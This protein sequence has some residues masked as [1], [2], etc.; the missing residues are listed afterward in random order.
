MRRFRNR[1]PSHR[2]RRQPLAVCLAAILGA[3]A[4]MAGHGVSG[5]STLVVTNCDDAGAGSLRDAI[6][7]AVSGDTIDLRQLGCSLIT[8]SGGALAIGPPIAALNLLGPG[9]ASLTIDGADTDRI[10]EHDVGIDGSLSISGITLTH[11]RSSGDGGCVSVGGSVSLTDVVVASCIV[12][13]AP[14]AVDAHAS[15][16]SGPNGSVALHGGGV[17]AKSSA[18]LIDSTVS[19]NEVHAN[20][21]RAY[22]GGVY[23]ASYLSVTHSTVSGNLA[24]SATVEAYGGG[25]ASGNAAGGAQG[26]LVVT[27]S[28]LSSNTVSSACEVCLVKG[29]A[30]WSYG[31]ATVSGSLIGANGVTSA[32]HYA[33]GG[34]MYFRARY[35]GAPV[36]ATLSDTT[37]TGNTADSSAGGIGAGGSLDLIRCTLSDNVAGTDGGAVALFSGDMHL[38]DSTLSGNQ[39]SGRGGGAFLFGYGD[40][41]ASN[42]TISANSADRGGAFANTYGSLHLANS[43]IAFNTT[44]GNGGG[45]YFRY[46]SYT[47]D[48]QSTIVAG[49]QAVAGAQDIWAPG[50]SVSGANNLVM[51]APDVELPADT[52][53]DDPLLQPLADNG[54]PTRTHAFRVGS[55]AI[56]A[57][58]NAAALDFDQRGDGFVRVYGTA[59][60]IGAFEQ[61]PVAPLDRIFFDGFE[62]L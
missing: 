54:G 30:I 62:K 7:S 2:M 55:P 43:T 34:A 11:G 26:L 12:D 36:S 52:L 31:N 21:G 33:A 24:A 28:E 39:A 3:P 51:A 59:A 25:I 32:G 15:S 1:S 17:F 22:G 38:V 5:G 29:G 8:L 50:L 23:A 47:L 13:D 35:G 56:D 49:N 48:L 4:A 6:V 42:S 27:D 20:S 53:S 60:D 57:G 19:G 9:S 10:F 41:A 46:P 45:I 40:I 14:T 44:T 37:V 58:N 16:A 18:T 61:Q